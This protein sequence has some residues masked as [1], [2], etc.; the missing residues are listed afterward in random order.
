MHYSL[1][2]DFVQPCHILNKNTGRIKQDLLYLGLFSQF[3]V[4]FNS[5][6]IYIMILVLASHNCNAV[7]LCVVG[8][9]GQ[10]SDKP[11][12]TVVDIQC[13]L[14]S[15]GASEL[16]ID[17]IVSTKNDRVF[18]ESILLG[19][20]LL[21][22]GNTQTQVCAHTACANTAKFPAVILCH[23]LFGY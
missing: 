18:E 21:R 17:L 20:A 14:D 22:G 4:H 10:D 19:I 16:V 6:I 8:S 3:R 11:G 2:N 1:S 12:T 15:V 7:C 23:N 5:N 13:L 9:P